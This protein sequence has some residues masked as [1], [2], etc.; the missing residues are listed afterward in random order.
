MCSVVNFHCLG[1]VSWIG[2]QATSS[3]YLGSYQQQFFINT[4]G[5][6]SLITDYK[7]E[8]KDWR[9][10]EYMLS[11]A[12]TFVI[13]FNIYVLTQA[14]YPSLECA[15]TGYHHMKYKDGDIEKTATFSQPIQLTSK[16]LVFVPLLTRELLG[17]FP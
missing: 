17:L 8:R 12:Q 15:H 4:F 9:T 6:G 13:P 2:S 3:L 1:V 16:N 5:I 10:G 14:K 7:F 11:T